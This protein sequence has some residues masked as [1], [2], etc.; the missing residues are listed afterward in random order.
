MPAQASTLCT[1][2]GGP[3]IHHRTP[4][5]PAYRPGHVRHNSCE[6]RF[7][8]V[9]NSAGTRPR[10]VCHLHPKG[11][12]HSVPHAWYRQGWSDGDR[13]FSALRHRDLS[14]AA[15][16]SESRH[17]TFLPSFLMTLLGTLVDESR[18]A[19]ADLWYAFTEYA[20]MRFEGRADL[21]PSPHPARTH[22]VQELQA[23]P[24]SC[25]RPTA[26]ILR[27][28]SFSTYRLPAFAGQSRG[29]SSSPA[30][31]LMT[32]RP[33]RRVVSSAPRA[34]SAANVPQ[35][36]LHLQQLRARPLQRLR[37]V[38]VTRSRAAVLLG[39]LRLQPAERPLPEQPAASSSPL[40]GPVS[41]AP[42]SSSPR[43]R[44][45]SPIPPKA[46]PNPGRVIACECP[47]AGGAPST[48]ASGP[49]GVY[50][51]TASI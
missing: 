39:F 30:D 25:C 9:P 42:V 46:T 1:L 50:P 7:R 22:S 45:S 36:R 21:L 16:D 34:A 40:L 32:Q 49:A 29:S 3:V 43:A 28:P 6:I 35:G 15:R 2:P 31:K 37:A 10:T 5:F 38:F 24:A 23:R 18:M 11:Q 4:Q 14:L 47:S 12:L 17:R 33:L 26:Q 48:P 44:R 27:Q 20:G 8:E 51:S 13:K 41:T 19:P